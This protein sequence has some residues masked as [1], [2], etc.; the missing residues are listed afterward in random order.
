MS[1]TL[2]FWCSRI[3]YHMKGTK[4][5]FSFSWRGKRSRGGLP[6]YPE[7]VQAEVSE[8]GKTVKAYDL[9]LLPSQ[10]STNSVIHTD[11]LGLISCIS[12]V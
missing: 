8:I 1:T 9:L 4:C 3:L 11:A 6:Q 12:C 7:I 2:L 5:S 10:S